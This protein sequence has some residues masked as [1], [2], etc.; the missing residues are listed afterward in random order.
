MFNTKSKIRAIAIV[1]ALAASAAANAGFYYTDGGGSSHAVPGNN[2]FRFTDLDGA[3]V[4]SFQLGRTLGLYGVDKNDVVEIDFF[5]AEAGYRNKFYWGNTLVI[6]NLG[7]R[8]WQER[9]YGTQLAYN[10]SLSFS[11]C[12][13]DVNSCLSNAAN[14]FKGWNSYQSIGMKITDGGSTAW[15]LWDDSGANRDDDHD[16]LIVRLRHVSV[17]EPGSLALLGVALLGVSLIRRRKAVA[18]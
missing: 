12:A 9:D 17:P 8:S 14:N 13:V 6:N 2:D 18:A 5:A 11:F 7:N 10:G 3:G 4:L 15:L 16:D 1:A